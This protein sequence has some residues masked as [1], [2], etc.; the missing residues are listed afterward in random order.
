M[1]MYDTVAAGGV[2]CHLLH[3]RHCSLRFS[4]YCGRS[5][6]ANI[7]TLAP[8][9]TIFLYKFVDSIE[10]FVASGVSLKYFVH[11]KFLFYLHCEWV[12]HKH[13]KNCKSSYVGTFIKL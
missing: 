11:Q 8:F 12:P 6:T 5:I 13:K 2:F 3:S 9:Q 4:N 10:N 1:P 7:H